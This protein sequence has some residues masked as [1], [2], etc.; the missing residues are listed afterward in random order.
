MAD[1]RIG[2]IR[3]GGDVLCCSQMEDASSD[4]N[5]IFTEEKACEQ[6]GR[7]GAFEFSGTALCED[8]YQGCGSCCPGFDDKDRD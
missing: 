4:K 8:C 1:G 3:V 2:R 5:Q 6:C 7:Y